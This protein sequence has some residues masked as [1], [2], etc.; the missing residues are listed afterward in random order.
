[1]DAVRLRR[2]ADVLVQGGDAVLDDLLV[3]AADLLSVTGATISVIEDGQ[4]RG[5]IARSGRRFD[6]LDELQFSLGEGPAI[7]ADVARLPVL[8]PDL[9]R[10]EHWP[11]FAA[12]AMTLC[13]GAVFAFPLQL[14][15]L[16]LGVLTL[17]RVTR[18]DLDDVDVRDAVTL[19]HVATH[20]LLDVEGESPPGSVPGRLRDVVDHR[21][22][23]HQATGMIAAQ[24][25]VDVATA[26]SRLRAH[27]WSNDRS[28]DDVSADVVARRIR[29][30]PDG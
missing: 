10:A 5:A 15:A 1:V 12:E 18:G 8:E 11:S 7:A 14:G 23:V 13:M 25:S 6:A 21:A 20:V 16:Q 22:R 24:R 28:I 19:T 9:A 29:F 3:L 27:A 26:L 30:E 2:V 4:H 17:Y